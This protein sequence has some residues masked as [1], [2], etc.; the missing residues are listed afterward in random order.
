M[1]DPTRRDYTPP[2]LAADAT[3]LARR[4]EPLEG[5]GL[6][7]L[8]WLIAMTLFGGITL[9]ILGLSVWSPWPF[10]AGLMALRGY[11]YLHRVAGEL[12]EE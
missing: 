11:F 4:L 6:L 2:A 5:I 3:W 7:L 9:L 12:L 1:I 8:Q 10:L